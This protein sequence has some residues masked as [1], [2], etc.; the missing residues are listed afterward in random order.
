MPF[1]YLWLIYLGLSSCDVLAQ[2]NSEKT[3]RSPDQEFAGILSVA[4]SLSES[5]PDSALPYGLKALDI[6]REIRK[7]RSVADASKILGDIYTYMLAYD[8]AII[9][10][11]NAVVLERRLSGE[12]SPAHINRTGDVAYCFDMLEQ[13]D[14]ALAWYRKTLN[15]AMLADIKDE[16]AANL[17]NIGRIETIRGNYGE[18]ITLMRQALEIDKAAGNHETVATDLNTIG[19]IYQAWGKNE[20]AIGYF[21]QALAL[22]EAAGRKAKASIRLNSI[23]LSYREMG[24]FTEA[25]T[26]FERALEIDREM[27]D[28]HKIA[29]RLNNLGTTYAA[30]ADFPEAIGK[31]EEAV[32]I[33]EILDL[34]QEQATAYASLAAYYL[35]TG[36]PSR[37]LQDA[38]KSLMYAREQKMNPLML[39]NYEM[40][41][42]ILQQTGDYKTALAY[43]QKYDSLKNEIFS[44]ESDRRIAEF[45]ALYETEKE[46][47]KNDL[48]LK[49]AQI[50]KKRHLLTILVSAG[51]VIA[52]A[53]A[54]IIYRL[55]AVSSRRRKELAEERAEKLNL[56]LEI[57]NKELTYNA[58]SIIRSNETVASLVSEIDASLK[59][60]DPPERIRQILRGIRGIEKNEAWREFEVRFSR[61][62]E[63]FYRKL[64]EKFPDLTPNERKLCAFLRLNMSTKDIANLTHQDVHTIHVARTRLRKKLNLANT[65]ENLV[66]FLLN[67]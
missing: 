56:E 14:T 42:R 30:M 51:I 18:A 5:M 64:Q 36:N 57:R 1:K 67:L 13:H 34:P 11:K 26:Y 15:L 59:N 55:A 47:R 65:D 21:E 9:H 48:L 29:L 31:L 38:T 22:D 7:D 63:E 45:N 61:V 40:M 19:R 17:A 25:V 60:G 4:D 52:L 43:F 53:M 27:D 20:E 6:A 33:F 3:A 35:G 10:Y 66:T 62:H 46:R 41:S 23:G 32:G 50:M 24:Q 54:A 28:R 16:I 12:L 44:E 39:E 49:D 37:A 8:S 2:G 58:M